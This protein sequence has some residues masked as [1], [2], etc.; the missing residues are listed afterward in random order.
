MAGPVL[1]KG[2]SSPGW[3]TLLHVP[4]ATTGILPVRLSPGV[5]TDHR[6]VLL[7]SPDIVIGRYSLLNPATLREI[8]IK[9]MIVIA[10]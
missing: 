10:S 4:Y 5:P 9:E 7:P 2:P 8:L 1:W 3:V 6:Q